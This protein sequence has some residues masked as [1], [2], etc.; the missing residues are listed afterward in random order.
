MLITKKNRLAILSYLF[1][2]ACRCAQLSCALLECL[3]PASALA[4][5]LTR[6][7]TALRSQRA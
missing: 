6:H 4:E 1:K 7:P 2:G 3:G 5:A